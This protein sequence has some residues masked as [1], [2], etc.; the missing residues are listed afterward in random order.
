MY[1]TYIYFTIVPDEVGM[2]NLT[3]GAENGFPTLLISWNAVPSG[4]GALIT[5]TVRYSISS[6]TTTEPPSGASN[7]TGIIGTSTILNGLEQGTMYYIWVAAVSSDGQGPYSTRVS[8]TTYEG[9]FVF[10]SYSFNN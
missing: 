9:K 1:N 2:V 6:G 4:G 5:Y 10:F 7:K 3:R 8:E